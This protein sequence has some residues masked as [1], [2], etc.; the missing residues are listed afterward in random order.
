MAIALRA[1]LN[2][3]MDNLLTGDAKL[4]VLRIAP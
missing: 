2:L 3:G 1:T 4:S